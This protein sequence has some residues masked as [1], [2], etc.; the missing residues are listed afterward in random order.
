MFFGASN[1]AE[2]TKELLELEVERLVFEPCSSKRGRC[3]LF[4]VSG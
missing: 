1:R 4:G 2:H 3:E